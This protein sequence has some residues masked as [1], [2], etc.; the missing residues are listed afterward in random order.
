MAR[1]AAVPQFRRYAFRCAVQMFC[2]ESAL[3]RLLLSATYV[4]GAIIT[5]TRA[6]AIADIRYDTSP[7]CFRLAAASCRLKAFAFASEQTLHRTPNMHNANPP[8]RNSMAR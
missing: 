4:A 5:L 2:A 8:R 1:A 3:C 6:F 7:R